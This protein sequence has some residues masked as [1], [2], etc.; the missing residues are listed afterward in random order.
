VAGSVEEMYDRLVQLA[1]D[2]ARGKVDPLSIDISGYIEV[3]RRAVL[4]GYGLEMLYK[5]VRA[6]SGLV[7]ILEAQYRALKDRGMGLYLEPV[8]VKLRA[9]Q[10]SLDALASI[11]ARC[12]SPAVELE[13]VSDEDFRRALSYFEL[14]KPIS[15][16]RRKRQYYAP[17]EA[18]AASPEFLEKFEEKLESLY[19]ELEEVSGGGWIEYSDFVSRGD[20]VERAYLLSFLIT[21]GR[22]E[23]RYRKLEDAYY[24]RPARGE[25]RSHHSIVVRLEGAGREG[26]SEG[27]A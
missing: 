22:V 18:P 27:E 5:D 15:E 9:K 10:L 1:L 20:P 4:E 2:V 12:W 26:G 24:V 3:V 11:A 7:T 14:L 21:S 6:L 16:R 13:L 19:R 8:L 17:A 25:A 23:M